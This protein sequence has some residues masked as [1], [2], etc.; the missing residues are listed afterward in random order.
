[1]CFE[2][3]TQEFRIK[4]ITFHLLGKIS[5]L[6]F[7]LVYIFRIYHLF[8]F[9]VSKDKLTIFIFQLNDGIALL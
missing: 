8:I 1:M 5:I 9:D 6:R 3:K 4:L 2:I 7:Q